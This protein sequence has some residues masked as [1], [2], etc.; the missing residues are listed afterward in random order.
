MGPIRFSLSLSQRELVLKYGFPTA[1]FEA[2]LRTFVP[3]PVEFE[4]VGFQFEE[5]LLAIA[6]AANHTKD[7]KLAE[8]LDDLHEYLES[9]KEEPEDDDF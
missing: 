9:V 8:S 4:L 1:A 3:K 5:L 7:R 2:S 6:K